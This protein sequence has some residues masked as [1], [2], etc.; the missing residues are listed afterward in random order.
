MATPRSAL[1]RGPGA[2]SL[3]TSTTLSTTTNSIQFADDFAA[4]L[5]PDN[6][7]LETALQGAAD[8]TRADLIIKASGTPLIYTASQSTV[9][10]FLF[11]WAGSPPP[12]VGTPLL[13]S[14][15]FPVFFMGNNGDGVAIYNAACAKQP[16]LTLAHNKPIIDKIEII[17]L[18]R[19]NYDPETANSYYKIT[20]G[21]SWSPPKLGQNS[22]DLF[23]RQ[24]YY[25]NWAA[26]NTATGNS[27]FTNFQ[28]QNG[29]VISHEVKL[30]PVKIQGR[31]IDYTLT[32]YRAMAKMIP[33]GPSASDID[34]CAQLQGSGAIHGSRL[35]QNTAQGDLIITGQIGG[36]FTIKNAVLKTEGFVFGGKPLRL[37]EI[38]FV[39]TFNYSSS[40]PSGGLV[41]A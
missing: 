22:G 36:T 13:G 28:G 23:G 41:L 16:D 32:S 30:E 2:L 10:D 26:G 14:A 21:G 19:N 27:T 40:S 35:S 37:G 15:D 3:N 39:G 5:A 12:N 24:R 34:L 20:S 17:G 6:E 4:I 8:E 29:I 1:V 31:T 11:P 38:G 33:V 18:L 25:A 7:V 9:L